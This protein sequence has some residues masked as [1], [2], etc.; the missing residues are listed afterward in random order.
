MTFGIGENDPGYAYADRPS[1][2]GPAATM[3]CKD[4][5]DEP[6][7]RF[8]AQRPGVWHNWNF[9]NENDVHLAMPPKTPEKLVLGKMRMLMR[10]GLVTGCGCGCRGDFEI[11]DRGQ[12]ELSKLAP[13]PELNAV[14]NG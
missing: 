3:Q 13:P 5:P 2:G 12:E 14:V 10:R 6:I 1:E 7:L 11:T 4:I 8:L 9:G